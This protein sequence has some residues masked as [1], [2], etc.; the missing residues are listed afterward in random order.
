MT[1]LEM[2]QQTFKEQIEQWW[3]FFSRTDPLFRVRERNWSLFQQIGLPDTSVEAFRS[4]KLRSLFSN[5]YQ[6]AE[7]PPH[8][9]PHEIDP[10]IYSECKSSCLVFVNGFYSPSLSRCEALPSKLIVM[11]LSEAISSYGVL[12]NNYWNKSLK[13]EVDPFAVLNGAL[14]SEG[15]FIYVSP[16]IEIDTP[17]QILHIIDSKDKP[18]IVM[19]RLQVFMGGQSRASFVMTQQSVGQ[20]EFFINQVSEFSLDQGAHVE[21][22]QIECS[23]GPG[24][25]QMDACRA[26]LKRDSRFKT[27]AVTNGSAGIRNDYRIALEGENCE[28]LLNGLAMLAEKRESHVH[29]FMDHQA[30]HC[31]SH[32]HFKSVLNDFSRSSF[33]GKIMVRQLAQKTEAF[34]LNNNL[35]LS[36]HVKADS[37]PNLEIFADDVKAS[38]GATVGQLDQ[39]QVFYMKTR[40]FSEQQAKKLLIDGFCQEIIGGL[41]LPSLLNDLTALIK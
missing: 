38:H 35:L 5:T 24:V 16:K 3:S 39:E 20:S 37:K 30:P 14:H 15:L 21:F 4:I 36:D 22:S 17:I 29:I 41:S 1:L 40:G 7:K 28:A 26:S 10:F 31:R 2:E 34:Q 32:Q 13:E 12:L 23:Y 18:L 19:P 6:L 33:E 8:L 11:P 9:D 25:W 27:I